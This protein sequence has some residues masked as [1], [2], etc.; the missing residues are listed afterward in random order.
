MYISEP[1]LWLRADL[2]HL[3]ASH[4]C[5]RPLGRG[6]PSRLCKAVFCVLSGSIVATG[7]DPKPRGFKYPNLM[8][9]KAPTAIVG[10][11]FWHPIS[12][13]WSTWTLWVMESLEI[14]PACGN[15]ALLCT[16]PPTGSNCPSTGAVDPKY[17]TYS[18]IWSPIPS[19]LGTWTLLA[20]LYACA[21]R[22]RH[23]IFWMTQSL[24]GCEAIWRLLQDIGSLRPEDP[25]PQYLRFL[26][27]K[28]IL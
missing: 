8:V 10:M 2:E 18:S 5:L 1:S 15:R 28:T 24:A 22:L 6:S 12:P 17:H 16:A 27:P 21:M 26:V 19:C 23:Y 13:D 14:K 3:K 25:S 9:L 7:C 20:T 11:V 4:V